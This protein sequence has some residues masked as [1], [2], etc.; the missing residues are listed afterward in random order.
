MT[1]AWC[2]HV[3]SPYSARIC[4]VSVTAGQ[5]LP[6][7]AMSRIEGSG[8]SPFS[9]AMLLHTH[10]TYRHT[11]IHETHTQ[12]QTDTHTYTHETHTYRHTDT[13]RHTDRSMRQNGRTT[14]QHDTATD[15]PCCYAMLCYAMLCYAMLAMLHYTVLLTRTP[16]AARSAHP[17]RTTRRSARPTR[18]RCAPLRPPWEHCHC[19]LCLHH[20]SCHCLYCH[21]HCLLCLWWWRCLCLWRGR[22]PGPLCA[23]APRC[24][25]PSG[26]EGPCLRA[27]GERETDRQRESIIYLL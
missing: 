3:S 10:M 6:S 23:P 25:A 27:R 19:H 11:Y 18:P 17:S 15:V 13:D 12:T 26:S 24:P 2:Q 4:H 1:A 14:L 21:C 7:S 8:N 16:R 5:H 9:T 20:Y 22:T